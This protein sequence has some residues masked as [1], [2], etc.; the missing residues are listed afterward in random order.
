MTPRP[1]KVST[2]T[3]T[4]QRLV[5]ATGRR[6]DLLERQAFTTSLAFRGHSITVTEVKF[7]PL[8]NL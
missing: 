4:V 3:R 5:P 8:L 1:R 6:N 7:A 2:L